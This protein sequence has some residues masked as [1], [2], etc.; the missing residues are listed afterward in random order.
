MNKTKLIIFRSKEIY[1]ILF[2]IKET[3]KFD[4]VFADSELKV[5]D[6]I[7]KNNFSIVLVKT[8][9]SFINQLLIKEFPISISKLVQAI[10]KK[11]LKTNFLINSNL[12]IGNYFLDLNSKK[13]YKDK[14]KIELT[15]QEVKILVYLN[16]STTLKSINDFYENIWKYK[17]NLETHTVETHI[18]RLRKKIAEK[19]ND[20]NFILS[21]KEGYYLKKS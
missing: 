12:K 2:E 6:Y 3:I 5:N 19:F 1:N 7:K 13:I 4:V 9:N 20:R 8:K 16:S 14:K 11:I 17:C 21:S 15:E 10:N 18:Y